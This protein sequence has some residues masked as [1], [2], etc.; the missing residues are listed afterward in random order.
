VTLVNEKKC[1]DMDKN[2]CKKACIDACPFLVK[3]AYN[4]EKDIVQMCNMCMQRVTRGEK[5]SCVKHCITQCLHFG[6]EEELAKM[7]QERGNRTITIGSV[8]ANAAGKPAIKYLMP[9][10]SYTQD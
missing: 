7:V 8:V 5:P 10:K 6:T 9:R 4:P 1:H 2:E 3:P